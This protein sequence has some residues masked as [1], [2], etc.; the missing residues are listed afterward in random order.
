[1]FF[2]VILTYLSI[3]ILTGLVGSQVIRL[4]Q[5]MIWSGPLL[6]SQASSS[7]VIM[8][9]RCFDLTIILT[10]RLLRAGPAL[11]LVSVYTGWSPVSRAAAPQV[12]L[13]LSRITNVVRLRSAPLTS[14]GPLTLECYPHHWHWD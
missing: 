8:L 10:Q 7:A 4:L 5:G 13:S 14:A 2:L 1:M 12:S 3:L 6:Y 11:R 9:C